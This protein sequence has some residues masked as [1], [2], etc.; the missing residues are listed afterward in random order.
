MRHFKRRNFYE[1]NLYQYFLQCFVLRRAEIEQVKNPDTLSTAVISSSD[2][3]TA[4]NTLNSL[5]E[6]TVATSTA[7]KIDVSNIGDLSDYDVLYIDK[8]VVETGGFNA[9]AVEEYVSNGGSVFS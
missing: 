4:K 8:S 1:K 2:S 7:D 3:V 5:N 9:S 6:L